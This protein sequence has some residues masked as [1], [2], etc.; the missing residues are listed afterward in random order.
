MHGDAVRENFFRPWQ[1]LCVLD[2]DVEYENLV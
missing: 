2:K 1:I